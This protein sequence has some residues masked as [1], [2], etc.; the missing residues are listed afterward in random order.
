MSLEI[1]DTVHRHRRRLNMRVQLGATRVLEQEGLDAAQ[2]P[3]AAW[4]TTYQITMSP[5]GT[6]SAQATI[7]R[8]SRL[9]HE[10]VEAHTSR[11]RRTGA[12]RLPHSD[13]R[14]EWA[15]QDDSAVQLEGVDRWWLPWSRTDALWAPL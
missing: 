1:P 7:Y 15:I 9:S 5:N 14:F 4:P 3:H 2:R 11:P 8:T 6:P 13:R 10:D 12:T